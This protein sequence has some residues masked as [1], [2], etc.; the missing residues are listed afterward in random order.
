[1]KITGATAWPVAMPLDEPYTIAYETIASATNVFVRLETDGALVGYGCAAPDFHVT[2]E[3]PESVLV[4][5]MGTAEP[6]LKGED[7]A[8]RVALLDRVRPALRVHS[9]AMAAVDMA[10][11]DLVA[12]AAGLP[13]WRM[14]GGYRDHVR[15][16]ITVGILPEGETLECAAHWV[17][18]G[19]RCLK[20]KGGKDVE[21]D[22][23]RVCK[24][25]ERFGARVEIR[26][27]ANQGY[28]VEQAQRLLEG[29]RDADLQFLEQPTP[30]G[31]PELLRLVSQSS[32][33]PVMADE[34]LMGLSDARWLVDN[35]LVD[36][37]NVKLM[38]VGGLEEASEINS[39]AQ[40]RGVGVMVGCMDEAELAI[41][42][43]LH[44]ALAYQNVAYADLDG[45]L[46]LQGDPTAGTL[47]LE[48][49]TLHAPES[50]GLGFAGDL[51]G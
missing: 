32:A 31:K 38:K 23:A 5:I 21:G 28:S 36:M 24:V 34:S 51:E 15:T 4:A 33:V 1:M 26:F 9:S 27:D 41:A 47:R 46:G 50:P 20:L 14:L 2:G 42:A 48:E 22:I 39:V 30:K 25:R 19:F 11:H 10:L 40:K 16:S 3:T 18:Q 8:Q 12:K 43:G 49:G 37:V 7:P 13:L 35:G 45:H 29:T 17:G 44:Y 6:V